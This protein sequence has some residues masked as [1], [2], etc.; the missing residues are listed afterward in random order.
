MYSTPPSCQ[1]DWWVCTAEWGETIPECQAFH[2][3][4]FWHP[5]GPI[6]FRAAHQSFSSRNQSR[7]LLFLPCCLSQS[8]FQRLS[9]PGQILSSLNM[10][11]K[12]SSYKRNVWASSRDWQPLAQW[13]LL[14]VFF[15]CDFPGDILVILGN[16]DSCLRNEGK[17]AVSFCS[18]LWQAWEHPCT[19][20]YQF[21]V[22]LWKYV[23][24]VPDKPQ[25]VNAS[26]SQEFH[27][28]YCS[29]RKRGMCLFHPTK[30]LST[31]IFLNH[32]SSVGAKFVLGGESILAMRMVC[33]PS[34]LTST[35]Q[36]LHPR[37]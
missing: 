7:V 18:A 16:I 14:K 5:R 30:K 33:G 29:L 25:V 37:I 36:N 3:A 4:A 11:F 35:Q 31:S 22:Q 23:L 8:R 6:S 9:F 2:F 27:V 17:L 12:N 13:F 20:Y 26:G 28:T 19:L 21:S 34:K 24:R 1:D 15:L 10:F 32:V